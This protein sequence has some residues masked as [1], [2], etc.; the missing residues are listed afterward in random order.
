MVTVFGALKVARLGLSV[1]RAVHEA[2]A[3]KQSG[4]DKRLAV[5]STFAG[6]KHERLIRLFIEIAVL[7][8]KQRDADQQL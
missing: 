7:L 6:T 1:V 5:L 4:Q 2:D 8:L 3:V